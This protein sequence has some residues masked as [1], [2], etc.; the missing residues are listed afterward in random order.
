MTVQ[1]QQMAVVKRGPCVHFQGVTNT[2]AQVAM[3]E[4]TVVFMQVFDHFNALIQVAVP[5]LPEETI[6]LNIKEQDIAVNC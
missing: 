3:L 6:A 2:L 1:Q 5:P 4:G